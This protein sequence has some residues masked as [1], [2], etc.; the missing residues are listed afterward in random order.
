MSASSS[1]AV[2]RMEGTRLLL[3]KFSGFLA[4]E[5]VGKQDCEWGDGMAEMTD[6]VWNVCVHGNDPLQGRCGSSEWRDGSL[7]VRLQVP[8]TI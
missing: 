4:W 2:G 6:L 7:D 5:T 3:G 8:K 1:S